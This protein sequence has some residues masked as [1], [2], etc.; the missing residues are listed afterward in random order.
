M[1]SVT[2]IY[3]HKDPRLK[4]TYE[5]LNALLKS[6]PA[7][8]KSF[9]DKIYTNLIRSNASYPEWL[10]RQMVKLVKRRISRIQDNTINKKWFDFRIIVP[11]QRLNWVNRCTIP[12]G[13]YLKHLFYDSKSIFM[14]VGKKGK[15]GRVKTYKKSDI[16]EYELHPEKFCERPFA[17]VG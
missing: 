7:N 4:N 17:A 15:N 1:F 3:S 11:R 16:N 9:D 13:Y 12:E 6:I 8:A 14:T 10:K 2:K 5:D